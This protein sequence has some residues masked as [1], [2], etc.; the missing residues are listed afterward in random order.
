MS[1]IGKV[2]KPPIALVKLIESIGILFCI[3][4]SFTK[5][6]YKAPTPS[7]YDG[8][9]AALLQD[10]V[11]CI[12]R[13]GTLLSDGVTNEVASELYAKVLEP[14]FD[15]ESA[16]LA[17]G[18]EARDLYNCLILILNNIDAETFRI[19]IKRTN[20]MVL[21]DGSRPS[22]VA[23]DIGSHLHHHGMFIVGALLVTGSQQNGAVIHRHLPVDLERRCREQYKINPAQFQIHVVQPHT[24]DDIVHDVED[25]MTTNKCFI[26]VLGIDAN[27]TGTENLS[28]SAQWATWASGIVTVLVKSS[29]RIRPFTSLH[30]ARKYLICVKGIEVLDHLFETSLNLIK[31]GD[32]IIFCSIVDSGRP[33]GDTRD[34][35]YG[36]GRRVGW[37]AGAV[38]DP[39]E[40]NRVGWND[41]ALE[42]LENRMQELLKISQI[43]GTLFPP[44]TR[45]MP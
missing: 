35:R 2:S 3:P 18:L 38:V 8:T 30:L 36:L 6:I 43:P 10:F 44:T 16:V 33:R 9:M 40:P 14:G 24:S 27:Y 20:I 17:G 37:V 21:C 28:R 7:N 42:A 19:P 45:R 41:K 25:T 5:S 39:N 15:Y 34:T 31:P 13:L 26:L 32:Y 11:G 4:K 29:S 12:N 23:L 22:Y 1:Q